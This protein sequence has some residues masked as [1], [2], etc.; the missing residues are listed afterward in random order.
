[1]VDLPPGGRPGL[2]LPPPGFP[3]VSWLGRLRGGG[4]GLGGLWWGWRWGWLLHHLLSDMR[5]K[6]VRSG[7]GARPKTSGCDPRVHRQEG[8][9]GC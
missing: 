7:G 3:R 8:Q 4:S 2:A 6:E 5:C 1:M 9:V